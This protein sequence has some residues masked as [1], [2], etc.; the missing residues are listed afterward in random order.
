M[1]DVFFQELK[2]ELQKG[3]TKKGHPFH[4]FTLG[5]V[6]LDPMARLRTVV[7]RKVSEDLV[8][9]FYTDK[10][11]KKITHIKENNKISLLFYHPEKLLQLKIEGIATITTDAATRKKFWD[12][13]ELNSRK[14]YITKDAP[15]SAIEDPD[16]LEYLKDENYFCVVE[17]NPFKVEY[18]KLKRPNHLRIRFSK[19]E[20]E[21]QSEFLVP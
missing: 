4:Y 8:L 9:T 5:T 10:R 16:T 3:A 17:I 11:S 7:L 6:G 13:I 2:E 12:N 20:N 19:N 1:T 21:W 15:G 14:D 18:L